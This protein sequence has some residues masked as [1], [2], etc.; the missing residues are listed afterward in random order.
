VA[1]HI[2]VPSV[3]SVGSRRA[4]A[5]WTPLG[6]PLFRSLWIAAVVSYT[7][8]WM[9]N[10]GAGW[11]MTQLTTSPLMVSLVQA[12]AAIPVFVAVLPA[13]ALADMVDRRRLL[14]FTQSWMIAAAV[15]L[16]ILTLLHAVNPWVLLAFTFLMGFG[17]VMNDPAWQ[18]IT[19]EVV[20]PSQHASAV[21][22][23]SAGFNVARAAGPALGGLVVAAAGSGWSFLLNAAS[24]FGVVYFL[25][26]WKRPPHE[27]LATHGV[28]DA[29]LEGLRYVR[30][31]PEVRSVLIRTGAFSIGATSL[32]ALLPLICQPHGAQGY[33][34]LLTC[35]GLGAL[36][37]A[38]LL[39]RLKLQYSVDGLVAGATV[40]FA[41][42]TFAAGQVHSFEWLCLVLFTAGSAWIGILAC[43]NVVAQTMCPSWMRARALSMYLLVLQGGMAVGSAIWGELAARQG[44]PAALAWSALAMVIG[45]STIRRH[46]LTAAELKMAPAVVRD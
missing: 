44:V 3:P 11:L 31:A 29:I 1:D 26:K 4:D 16:G 23:N 10:V 39:P 20:S 8:T 36:G 33:G 2:T 37:G 38:A 22:L 17:A 9:Q 19:P 21:A 24:F 30:G 46:R 40:L 6:E 25:Y 18:A 12:A 5:A 34:F 15:V 13:G 28:T 43:F 27:P 32:L 45:L 41:A 42:M 35:F 14:L 7:G